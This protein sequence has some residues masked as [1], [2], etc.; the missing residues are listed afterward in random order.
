MSPT[1]A[2]AAFLK[3]L[4]VRFVMSG[5][6]DSEGFDSGKV[7]VVVAVAFFRTCV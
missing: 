2:F 1:G 3:E 7:V 4:H 6:S 5:A